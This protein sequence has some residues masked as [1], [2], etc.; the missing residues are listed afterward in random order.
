[1]ALPRAH[2]NCRRCVTTRGK[3]SAGPHCRKWDL[4]K[5][6]HSFATH[7]LQSGL[8]IKSLQELLGHKNIGTTEKYLRSLRLTSLRTRIEESNIA[9][10]LH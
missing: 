5:W 2:L 9:A 8:D 4:H 7:M 6:R 10:I 3:C 1:M